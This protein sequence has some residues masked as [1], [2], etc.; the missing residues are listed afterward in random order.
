MEVE[1]VKFSTV[2]C[3]VLLKVGWVAVGVGDVIVEF[4]NMKELL[5]F[6]LMV[7]WGVFCFC[8]FV[9]LNVGGGVVFR[10]SEKGGFEFDFKG[11]V[12]V[13]VKLEVLDNSVGWFVVIRVEVDRGLFIFLKLVV[14]LLEDIWIVLGRIRLKMVIV[15]IVGMVGRWCGGKMKFVVGEKLVLKVRVVLRRRVW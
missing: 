7:G 4:L 9:V 8:L 2:D 6:G 13:E 5:K 10:D 15:C 1:G 3:V 11:I 14:F 12:N